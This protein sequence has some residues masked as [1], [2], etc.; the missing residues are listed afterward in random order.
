MASL[1]FARAS[2]S[3]LPWETQRKRCQDTVNQQ[4]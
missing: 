4:I 3:S 2:C 1:M